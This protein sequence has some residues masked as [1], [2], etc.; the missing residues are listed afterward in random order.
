MATETGRAGETQEE[1]QRRTRGVAERG[2]FDGRTVIITGGAAG[3]G[4]AC[5][6]RFGSEGARVAVVDRDAERAAGVAAAVESAGG[7]AVAIRCDVGDKAAVDRMVAESVARFGDVDILVA[8]A[9]T[10]AGA[11]FLDLGED[12]FDR[13][14]RVNLKGVFLCG[15]AVARHIVA[16]DAAAGSR[17][18]GAIVNLSSANAVLAI[19]DQIAYTASKGGVNQLTKAMA[20]SLADHGIRVNAVGPG[21]IMTDILKGVANN[22]EATRRIYQRTPLG[23]IGAPSEIAAI[24]AFLASA[25]A[26]YMT[27]QTVYADGGRMALN[28]VVPVPDDV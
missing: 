22:P 25:D 16:R 26:S 7:T 11:A 10:I 12:E 27:G 14:I 28:Y 23:R 6:L 15:Q 2:R 4:E 21:S 13:V 20:L 8:N 19:A 24:V 3:I 1:T 5:A 18:G 9:G 17:R